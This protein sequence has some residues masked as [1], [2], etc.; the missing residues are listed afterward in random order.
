MTGKP[1]P[2]F[3]V[4]QEVLYFDG[5][6]LS[7]H[8]ERPIPVTITR[9]GRT[10]VAIER[11]GRE[12]QFDMTTGAQKRSINAGGLGSEIRTHEEH[13]RL[14]QRKAVVSELSDLGVEQRHG[15][16]FSEYSVE[17]LRQV[18]DILAADKAANG[19]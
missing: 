19:D 9:V 15:R 2:R 17:A 18:R 13:E 5:N 1:A 14:Q 7:R 12:V 8:R 4:G 3:H 6:D 16:G 10:N 11:Y